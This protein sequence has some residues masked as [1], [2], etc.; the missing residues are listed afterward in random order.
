MKFAIEF[1][2]H[3]SGRLGSLVK[4]DSIAY[5]TPVVLNYTKVSARVNRFQ[6]KS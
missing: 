6:E 5:K 2:S 1:T 3:H 4:A